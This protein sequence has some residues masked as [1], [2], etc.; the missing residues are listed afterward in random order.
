MKAT[1]VAMESDLVMTLITWTTIQNL[2]TT[3]LLVLI[4]RQLTHAVG[5]ILELVDF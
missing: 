5:G 4:Q 2:E 1:G 3:N